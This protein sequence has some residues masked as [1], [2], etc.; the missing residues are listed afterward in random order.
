MIQLSLFSSYLPYV[1]LAVMYVL[2]LGVTSFGR[3]MAEKEPVFVDEVHEKMIS[4]APLDDQQHTFDWNDQ[5][6][7]SLPAEVLAG[8]DQLII[9]SDGM[10]LCFPPGKPFKSGS[11]CYGKFARPP[12]AIS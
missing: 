9:R 8:D 5:V 7:F 1:T 10:L 6:Q 4:W 3:L 2:Y 11:Y 12:P